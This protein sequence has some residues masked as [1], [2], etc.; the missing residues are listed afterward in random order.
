MHNHLVNH[1]VMAHWNQCF[2]GSY[3]QA[4]LACT[5]PAVVDRI[6]FQQHLNQP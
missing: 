1:D 4:D 2:A 5:G 3:E 6:C